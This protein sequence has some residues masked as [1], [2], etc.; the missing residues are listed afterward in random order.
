MVNY[1]CLQEI[2]NLEII[3]EN[4][5]GKKIDF[6]I[7]PTGITQKKLVKCIKLMIDDNLSLICAYDKL[8]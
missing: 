2:E 7:I 1:Q 6:S 5:Y 8:F 3:Y 4:T